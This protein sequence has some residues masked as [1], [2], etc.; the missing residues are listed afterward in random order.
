M[1][2]FERARGRLSQL[3]EASLLMAGLLISGCGE[4]SGLVRA[5]RRLRLDV[6]AILAVAARRGLSVPDSCASCLSAPVA[7]GDAPTAWGP[8]GPEHD[9]RLWDDAEPCEEP[10][11][12]NA[13]PAWGSWAF[14][15]S[16]WQS[17]Y[18]MAHPDTA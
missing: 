6:E 17:R 12:R 13:Y 9:G 7:A 8:D 4:N 14:G 3:A 11:S 1:T 16:A 18:L 10:S 5:S 15:L 2:D